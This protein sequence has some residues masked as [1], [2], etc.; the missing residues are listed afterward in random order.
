[1]SVREWR[2][3]DYYAVLEV[4]PS[5]S[6][7]A[8][9]AAF[10]DLAK[11]WHPDRCG[12][13][14]LAA[15]RFKRITAAHNVIGDP[16]TRAR[17]D[18]ERAMADAPAPPRVGPAHPSPGPGRDAAPDA[19]GA[20]STRARWD[21]RASWGAGTAAWTPPPAATG[22]VRRRRRL[23]PRAI[24]AI[25]VVL[26]LGGVLLGA[27][28]LTVGRAGASFGSAAVHTS[29][30]VVEYDGHRA[31]TFRTEDGAVVTTRP[32]GA[33]SDDAGTTVKVV[34]DRLDPSRA[35]VDHDSFAKEI[36]IWIAAVKLVV[37]GAILVVVSRSQR[38]RSWIA[39]H[40]RTSR[41]VR[42]APA[43]S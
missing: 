37:G 32:G 15:E 8:I 33:A 19:A 30:T 14:P 17:Y 35:V 10:R 18:R 11:R 6:D 43:S 40:T 38:L 25:G 39:E 7:A 22:R 26:L 41:I 42:Q 27:W 31:V 12:G 9:D 13:D 23:H 4:P 1:V 29:G 2:I 34:Y 16:S 5:A 20:R 3:T 21:D 36:T 28:R 24:L